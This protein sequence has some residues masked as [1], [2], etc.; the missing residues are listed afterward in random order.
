MEPVVEVI[1][2]KEQYLNLVDEAM[3][4]FIAF[5]KDISALEESTMDEYNAVREEKIASGIPK[6]QATPAESDVFA[7]FKEQYGLLAAPICSDALLKKGYGGSCAKPARY[8][9]IN[10][11]CRLEVTIK[12]CKQITVIMYHDDT[13]DWLPTYRFVLKRIE[14]SWKINSIH[15]RLGADDSWHVRG[16]S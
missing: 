6:W 14:D 2:T 4:A 1:G 8:G 10:E 13:K 7:R 11:G 16:L 15:Y 3:P 5:L 9:H 12:S